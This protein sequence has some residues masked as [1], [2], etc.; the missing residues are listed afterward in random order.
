MSRQSSHRSQPG[1]VSAI[2]QNFIDA[3]IAAIEVRCIRERDLAIADIEW[4][5][6]FVANS[7]R[8]V[9]ISP[10]YSQSGG[11]PA[12]AFA[13]GERALVIELLSSKAEPGA[14]SSVPRMRNAERRKLLEKELLCHPDCTFYAFDFA[15]VVLSIYIHLQVHL[16]NGIDIQSA[17]P[18]PSRSPE[19]SVHAVIGDALPVYATNITTAFDNMLY[20]T[21]KKKAEQTAL[22]QRAW[23][24]GYIGQYDS[25]N[26]KDMFYAAPKID[27][28]KF[29]KLEL[30]FMTK[31]AHDMLRLDILKPQSVTH[32]VKF[33]WND[34]AQQMKA[35]SQRYANRMIAGSVSDS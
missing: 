12:L 25:S 11:M 31:L 22:V 15:P 7:P 18:V 33:G 23:L 21:D 29:S 8:S 1:A 24:S 26:V 13:L 30:G 10:A 34:R 16:S 32:E 17:L 5:F 27:L 4:L 3:P 2:Y 6:G 14:D 28:K 9:G 20:G 19:D 35:Q